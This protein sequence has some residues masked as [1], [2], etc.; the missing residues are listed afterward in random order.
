MNRI[1]YH[2]L[3]STRGIIYKGAL[4]DIKEGGFFT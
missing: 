2:V 1:E 4:I 3:S